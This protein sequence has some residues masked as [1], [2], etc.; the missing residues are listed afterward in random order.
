MPGIRYLTYPEIDKA[1][2]NDCI[3]RA[4]NGK[5]YAYASYLD[6]MARHWDALVYNDYEA[7]MPLTWNKKYGIT[8]LYQPP[9]TAS[10]GIFGKALSGADV[11]AFLTA[12]PKKFRY[13][14]IFLNHDNLFALASHFMYERVNYILPLQEA[15][16]VLYRNFRESSRRHI[17]KCLQLGCTVIK[18]FDVKQVIEIA[19]ARQFAGGN[20]PADAYT[21]FEG[22][23]QTLY[24]KRAAMTYGIADTRNRLLASCVF[25]FDNRRAY[26]ILVGNLPDG[27]TAGASHA[28]INAFIEDHAGQDL[29]LDFEGSDIGNLAFFYS[30]FG[31]VRELYPGYRFNRLPFWAKWFKS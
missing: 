25:F 26:Y 21:R 16:P 27:R 22:L 12:I 23:Y 30:S 2:W 28:L 4:S 24:E 31:A 15:Y 9:F 11:E 18:D 20:P 10:L 7:V 17:R 6:A 8:Y 29:I 3:E 13:C 19:M 5:V 1:K 14:D